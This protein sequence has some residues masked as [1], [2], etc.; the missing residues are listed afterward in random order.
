MPLVVAN[1]A[2]I[3]LVCGWCDYISV[4]WRVCHLSLHTSLISNTFVPRFKAQWV[5][6]WSHCCIVLW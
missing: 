6:G 4:Y 3:S 5:S 2:V 1:V